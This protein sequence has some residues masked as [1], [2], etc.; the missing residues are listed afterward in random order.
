MSVVTAVWAPLPQR[1]F[2]GTAPLLYS[3]TWGQLPSIEALAE[4]VVALIVVE[5]SSLGMNE[6][7]IPVPLLVSFLQGVV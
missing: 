3:R 1:T 6:V 4:L 5:V 2:T 7:P